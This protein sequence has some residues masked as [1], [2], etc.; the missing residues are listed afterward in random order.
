MK[1]TIFA[2]LFI[3]VAFSIAAYSQAINSKAPDF[4]LPDLN[5]NNVKLSDVYSKGPVFVSFWATWCGPC[6]KE[7]PELISVYNKYHSRGFEILAVSIDKSGAGV[8]KPFAESSKLP[9]RILLDPTGEIFS[10]KYK[11]MGVPYGFLINKDGV[12]VKSYYGLTPGFEASLSKEVEKLLP[13]V[14]IKPD[15]SKTK[16]TDK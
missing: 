10:R 14:E 13:A 15:T 5:G 3:A 9:Y 12:V 4:T 1:K 2:A 11:G 6:K 16:E 8:V 7:I